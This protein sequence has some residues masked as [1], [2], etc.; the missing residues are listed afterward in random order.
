MNAR[1]NIKYNENNFKPRVSFS[2][3][4]KNTQ[5][6]GSMY[7]EWKLLCL[8]I[9]IIVYYFNYISVSSEK[10][11]I[12]VLTVIIFGYYTIPFITYPLVKSRLEN[13]YPKWQALTSIK[14]LAIFRTKDIIYDNNKIYCELPIFNNVILDFKAHNDFSDFLSE[15]DIREYKFVSYYKKRIKIGKK[16][17]KLRKANEFLWYARFYFSKIPKKGKL[18][19]IYK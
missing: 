14:K 16:Y 7:F 15:I 6:R 19:V 5:I 4:S 3:P 18:E 2:Y 1:I 8:I 12:L 17:K 13:L 11:P 10:M 9:T